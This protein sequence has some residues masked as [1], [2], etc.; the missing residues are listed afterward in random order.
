MKRSIQVLAVAALCA[1]PV[2][3]QRTEQGVVTPQSP[4]ATETRL[5]PLQFLSNDDAARLVSPFVE[6]PAGSGVF[7]PGVAIRGV[8]V[9]STK[10]SLVRIDSLI[11]ANDRAVPT[12]VLRFQLIAA[13]DAAPRDPAIP[14]D[15][16]ASLHELFRFGGYK[17]LAEG[18]AANG[19]S[20]FQLS[21]SVPGDVA[22][23]RVND[24][25]YV[26][27]NVI[28][29]NSGQSGARGV[30]LRVSLA[31]PGS[32]RG[33]TPGGARPGVNDFDT[34]LSTGLLVPFGQTAVLGS[35]AVVA[36]GDRRALI[37]TVRPELQGTP[38]GK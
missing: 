18:S 6:G 23:A 32:G 21:M 11:K 1:G 38:A 25:F 2:L 13:L 20:E 29:V 7:D 8:T 5:F 28:S 33:A 22:T 26:V 16:D 14:N 27:G 31:R 17:V 12:V 3:A 37:L 34:L 15:V 24:M 30:R 10:A 4:S 36:V 9:K 35:A 19:G